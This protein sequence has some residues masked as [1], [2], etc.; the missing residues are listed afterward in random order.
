MRALSP[1]EMTVETVNR[2]DGPTAHSSDFTNH[3]LFANSSRNDR[4]RREG[5]SGA[6]TGF[7]CYPV[8]MMLT[9]LVS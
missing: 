2:E 3:L 5:V 7:L 1:G 9:P 6:Q 8:L 4:V